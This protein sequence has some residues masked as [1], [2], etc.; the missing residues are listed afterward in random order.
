MLKRYHSD[1]S[2]IIRWDS[3]LLDENLTYE[4]VPVAILDRDVCKLRSKEIASVKVQW[5]N[6]P[7]EEATWETES[8]MSSKYPQ[9]F[10]GTR[11]A[12]VV[13]DALSCKSMGSLTDVYPERKEMVTEELS[14]GES[15]IAILDHQVRRLR[16][17]NVA[18]VKVLW[19]NN[20]KEEVSSEAE[21]EMKNKYPYLF[22]IPAGW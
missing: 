17:K 14:Y 3:V 2:Y 1:G 9:L 10:A 4:E 15:L 19:G 7:V 12:N 21:D 20:N 11:K 6:R 18:S 5:R 8:D 16:T 13:A 22:P